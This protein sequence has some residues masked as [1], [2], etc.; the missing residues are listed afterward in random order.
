MKEI[1]KIKHYFRYCDDIVIL[2]HFKQLLHNLLHRMT[3]YLKIELKLILKT[4]YQIFPILKRRLD[5][6]GFKFDHEKIYIR[7][8]IALN[9]KQKVKSIIKN[10]NRH[11]LRNGIMSYYGWVK[12]SKSYNLWNK[13]FTKEIELSFA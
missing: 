1:K 4:N 13:Y 5:F 2:H 3:D 7:K 11:N 6:L 12:T 10:P 8:N 9:F